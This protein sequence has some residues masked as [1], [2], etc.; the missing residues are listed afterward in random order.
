[1]INA[2]FLLDIDVAYDAFFNVFV[3][4]I[5]K[6]EYGEQIKCIEY[7]GNSWST[8]KRSSGDEIPK[9]WLFWWIGTLKQWAKS[10]NC[11]GV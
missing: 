10:S 3:Y 4:L 1:M 8:H 2:M 5:Y 11:V 6:S 9:R 7:V